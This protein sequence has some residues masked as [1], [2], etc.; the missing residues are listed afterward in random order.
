VSETLVQRPRTSPYSPPPGRGPTA[1]VVALVLFTAAVVGVLTGVLLFVFTPGDGG[2]GLLGGSGRTPSSGSAS[3]I[4][5][6]TVSAFDPRGDGHENDAQ[7]PL[8]HDGDPG[9]VWTTERYT[10]ADFGRLKS[11][12]GLLVD[13]GSATAVR[14]VTLTLT[15]AGASVQLRAGDAP[16]EAALRTVASVGPAGGRVT[17]TP[18]STTSARYWVVWFTSLPPAG[19]GYQAGIAEMAF[20]G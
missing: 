13:L 19:G 16:A 7:V 4:P 8:A 1:G 10:T 3:P 20:S 9:T 17:L 18:A 15:Q 14:S 11:G 6:R 12:V 5:L 2:A